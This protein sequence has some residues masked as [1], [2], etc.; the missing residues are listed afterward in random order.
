MFKRVNGLLLF[1]MLVICVLLFLPLYLYSSADQNGRIIQNFNFDWRFSN[2]PVEDASKINF[3]DHS[4]QDVNL[5]HD[6]SVY[7]AFD[8][9]WASGTGFLPAGIGWYRKSFTLPANSKGKKVFI[10]FDG[11]YDNSE[12]WINGTLLGK[13]PNGYISFQYDLTPYLNNSAKN[14][15]AV[16]V[17]HSKFADSRWYTGSGIYRDVKLITT[18]KTHIKQWGVNI[19]TTGVMSGKTT[20]HVEVSLLNENMDDADLVLR[21]FLIFSQDT[22]FQTDQNLFLPAQKDTVI[23]KDFDI[24]NPKLWDVDKANLYRLLTVITENGKILDNVTTTTGF[25]DIKFDSDKGFFLNGKNI[26]IKG[27]CLHHDAGCLGAAVPKKVIERRLDLLKEM[28]A[29]AIRTSHN[30]Y[31]S[32]FMDLCDEKGFLVM[33]EMFDEW[34]L[35]KKKWVE[36]WN[37]GQPSLDGSASFFRE[38]HRK[39][40]SD[41]ILRDRNHP[42]VIMW[43]IG[44]EIDYPNDPYSHP[45]LNS[46]DNPQTFAKY[47]PDRP[48]ANRLGEIAREL[49]SIVKQ[50]DTSRPVSAGLASAVVS[51]ETGYADALDIVGYNYQEM[52]YAADHKKYPGRPL[53]GSETGMSLQAW[54]AVTDNDYIM[55]QFLW[56]GIEYMGEARKFPTRNSTSGTIDL[57][58]NKKTEFY[59]R[60]SLWAEQPMVY[61]GTSQK[62][63]PDVASSLWSHKRFDSYWNAEKDQKVYVYAFTNC[64]EV[65]LFLNGKSLGSKKLAD[66]PSRVIPWDVPFEKGVLKA[67]AKNNG[68]E[69]AAY[70]LRTAGAAVQLKA[71]ADNLTLKADNE[72]IS[73]IEVTMCDA[74][75][76]NNVLTDGVVTCTVSG[77]VRLLGMEDANSRNVEPY[78]DNKQNTY[79]GRILLYIQSLDKQGKAAVKVTSPGLKDAVVELEIEN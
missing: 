36:G 46:S 27:V 66:Y 55:G 78:K 68:V 72:D 8:A 18:A 74:Q 23:S 58:G 65:E 34:E 70:E 6:W 41:F 63:M 43:S 56:T 61:I 69:K 64:R 29:N 4:W 79:Q 54:K 52:R 77:P 39:D 38:W 15:I 53:F 11:I 12:V 20:A 49:V 47:D 42:S 59:F 25:R 50:Y 5:P 24:S 44:N 13:R 28:G 57:A 32:T 10:D 1:N 62:E 21:H 19:N 40:L 31:S 22:I 30:P 26:K 67:L 48:D 75:G 35:P 73:H 16:K 60:Q 2:S 9:K 71:K 14:V 33:D 3:D 76:I 17:D 51:N 7:Q 45:I 37:A